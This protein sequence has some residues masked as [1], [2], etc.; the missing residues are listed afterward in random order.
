MPMKGIPEPVVFAVELG[1]TTEAETDGA[2]DALDELVPLT[3]TA[4]EAVPVGG[5]DGVA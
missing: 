2:V 4:F 5:E 3:A 1:N